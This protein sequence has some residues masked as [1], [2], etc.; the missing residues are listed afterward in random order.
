MKHN[1][2]PGPMIY[3]LPVVMVSC[4]IDPEDYNIFAV[5]WIG[6]L[7]SEPPLCYISIKPKRH[8][9]AIIKRDQQFVINLVTSD[10]ILKTDRSGLISGSEHQKFE[11][12]NLTA[13]RGI[14]VQA[15]IIKESPV[16]IECRVKSIVSL[17]SHDAFISEVVNLQIDNNLVD[18]ENETIDLNKSGL[19]A[20]SYGNYYRLQDIIGTYGWSKKK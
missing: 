12:L 1:W 10:L 18:V 16:N 20:F 8:S 9:H 13:E 2:K 7:S 3:P 19:V 14:M 17:G 15:P 5:S 6:T 4:G 11:M